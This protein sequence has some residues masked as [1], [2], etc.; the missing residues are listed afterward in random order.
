MINNQSGQ[1]SADNQNDQQERSEHINEH[2][3]KEDG[4]AI[5]LQPDEDNT[6]QT[7]E[8]YQKDKGKLLSDED[9]EI[10]TG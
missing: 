9:D 4:T 5:Y 10:T 8:E 7:P 6:L 1:E 2:G 3:K